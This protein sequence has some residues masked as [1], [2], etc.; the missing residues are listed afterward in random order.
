MIGTN[1][2]PANN[3]AADAMF[4]DLS[5]AVAEMLYKVPVVF[6]G[7]LFPRG[8]ISA[9][10][11]SAMN[12]YSALIA[13]LCKDNN[14]LVYWDSYPYLCDSNT[15][16]GDVI[17]SIAYHSDNLH[18][19]PY[20]AMLASR[21]IFQILQKSSMISDSISLSR[22]VVS[23]Q[24]S[25]NP[26][27]LF[28]GSG[29]TGSGS[30]GVTGTVPASVT[31]G[32]NGGT[33]ALAISKEL[34]ETQ[35][36]MLLTISGSTTSG[37]YH[38]IFQTATITP[39]MYG[40]RFKIKVRAQVNSATGLQ[41]L[42]FASIGA[43]NTFGAYVN[44]GG[45]AISNVTSSSNYTIDYLSDEFTMPSGTASVQVRLRIGTTSAGAAEV[46]IKEFSLLLA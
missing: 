28:L 10:Q 11:S 4:S 43:G 41:T 40:E 38:E 32:R 25:I 33:Q 22:G 35:D 12:Y 18:L 8:G 20:G 31:V 29:G 44:Q 1:D 19:M 36:A 34:G 30:N 9:G 45:R 5:Q 21:P 2:S 16:G 13:G 7:G 6:I 23:D 37:N 46:A 39:A 3:A 27:P 24:Y 42:E 17:K 26:N 15:V 14:R